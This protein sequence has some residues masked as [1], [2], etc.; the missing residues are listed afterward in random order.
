MHIVNGPCP[1]AETGLDD[2]SLINGL[3]AIDSWGQFLNYPKGH[4]LGLYSASLFFPPILTAYV[5]DFVSQRFGRRLA[6]AVG[7]CLAVAGSI[8]NALAV[9]PGMWIAGK[10]SL[11]SPCLLPLPDAR[12]ALRPRHPWC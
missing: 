8:I 1:Q 11:H 9:N 10:S 6:L 3:Q 4:I 7:S 12:S 2:T 5:G